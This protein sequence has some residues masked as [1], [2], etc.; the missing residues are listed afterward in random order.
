[1]GDSDAGDLDDDFVD[2]DDDNWGDWRKS[3]IFKISDCDELDLDLAVEK[4]IQAELIQSILIVENIKQLSLD[5]DSRD[6]KERVCR[7]IKI[8]SIYSDNA[9]KLSSLR[10]RVNFI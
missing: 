7:T 10:K 8:L 2:D 4:G 1:M 6:A 3:E 9:A 5:W